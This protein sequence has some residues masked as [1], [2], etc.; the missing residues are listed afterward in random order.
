MTKLLSGSNKIYPEFFR[1]VPISRS[2]EIWYYLLLISYPSQTPG[3]Q[4]T[5][6]EEYNDCISAED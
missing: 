6:A 1:D 2:H 5:G 4:S 3:A